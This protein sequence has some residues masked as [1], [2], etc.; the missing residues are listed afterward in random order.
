MRFLVFQHV[1]VEHPGSLLS[2]MTVAGDT[3]ETVELDGGEPIPPLEGFDALLI[4]GGPMDVWDEATL[5]WLKAEKA[6]IRRWVADLDR[7]LLGICLGHQLLAD[8]LGGRVEPMA[9]PEVGL[10]EVTLTAAA[11]ADPLFR[12]LPSPLPCLQWHGSAVTALPAGAVCLAGNAAAAVQAFRV[13]RA[14]Y[15]LQFHVEVTPTTVPEWGRIPAYHAALEGACG[16]GALERLAAATTARLDEL[17][18][19]ARRLYHNF[20]MLA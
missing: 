13:G 8:A 5:P 19:A 3:W 7:P 6:A 14:A 1:A 17:T 18:E 2:F 15:G 4:M 11:A 12:D 16:K 20:C 9:R 10:S